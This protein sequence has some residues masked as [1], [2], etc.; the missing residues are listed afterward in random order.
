MLGFE[1]PKWSPSYDIISNSYFKADL[2]KE[3]IYDAQSAGTI[4]VDA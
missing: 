1:F 3:Q 4:I 2:E